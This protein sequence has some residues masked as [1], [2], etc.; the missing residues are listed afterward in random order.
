MTWHVQKVDLEI[1]SVVTV[2]RYHV[3]GSG[4]HT[5]RAIQAWPASPLRRSVLQCPST[6]SAT[7]PTLHRD[8]QGCVC[9]GEDG[10]VGWEIACARLFYFLTWH[11][12]F[13]RKA[14][15]S[16]TG[17]AC[18]LI[19]LGKTSPQGISLSFSCPFWGPGPLRGIDFAQTKETIMVLVTIWYRLWN[20]LCYLLT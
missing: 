18:D 7:E 3:P 5:V 11:T 15:R 4:L 1:A 16:G 17:G 2:E 13:D 6:D 12:C 10:K 19:C 20:A 14:T 9:L 8:H